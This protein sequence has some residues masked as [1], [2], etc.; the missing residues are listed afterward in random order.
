MKIYVICNRISSQGNQITTENLISDFLFFMSL[1]ACSTVSQISPTS[2][3]FV[4]SRPALTLS[5]SCYNSLTV[6]EL[7]GFVLHW[8]CVQSPDWLCAC[9]RKEDGWVDAGKYCDN[10]QKG[11]SAKERVTTGKHRE[12]LCVY[13]VGLAPCWAT[14]VGH[15][16]TGCLWSL[17][18]CFTH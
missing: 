3:V 9:L 4:Y 2:S 7:G 12:A 5:L 13:I 14:S 18:V 8:W 10:G 17:C 15:R 1:S 11:E 16:D 6:D